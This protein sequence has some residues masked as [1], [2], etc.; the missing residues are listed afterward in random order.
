M[1]PAASKVSTR[2]R[3]DS[4]A[5]QLQGSPRRGRGFKL[6][7]VT[8]HIVQDFVQQRERLRVGHC[9]HILS[10]G[11]SVGCGWNRT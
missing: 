10:D 3:A 8:T 6:Q 11:E 5:D 7:E 1:G 2:K 9:L 4:C